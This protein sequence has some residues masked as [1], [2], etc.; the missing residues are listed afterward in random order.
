MK[1]IIKYQGKIYEL[2]TTRQG[3]E[4]VVEYAGKRYIVAP[5]E[6][7]SRPPQ[8]NPPPPPQSTPP[9]SPSPTAPTPT[10]GGGG[11]VTAPMNGVVKKIHVTTSQTVTAQQLVVSMEAMKMEVEVKT[12]QAGTVS[13]IA[14]SEGDTVEQG[15]QLVT[16]E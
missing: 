16:I 8:A 9:S 15:D 7:V 2:E 1:Q 3:N 14:V 13:A 11:A 10:P 12:S 6:V 5:E 4:I